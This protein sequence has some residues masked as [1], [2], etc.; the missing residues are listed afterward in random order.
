MRI[1]PMPSQKRVFEGW[2]YEIDCWFRKFDRCPL[3]EVSGRMVSM[4]KMPDKTNEKGAWDWIF[5]KL[6]KKRERKL[7]EDDYCGTNC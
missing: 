7:Q 3:G 6:N 4:L 1:L 2:V 5:R